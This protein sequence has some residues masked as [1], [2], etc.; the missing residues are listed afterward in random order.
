MKPIA[1]LL[2]GLPGT[3]K[4][5][6]AK[7]LEERGITRLTLDEE[8]FKR[9]GR[10]FSPKELI[11]NQDAVKT[12]FKRMTAGEIAAGHSVVVDSGF[13]K[14]TD[15]D[16]YKQLITNAGGIWKLVYFDAG[17]ETLQTRLAERNLTDAETEHVITADM[18]DSFI[19]QFEPPQGEGEQSPNE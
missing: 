4:T 17:T 18:L 8:V 6:Y 5:T 10:N 1:Y 14:K 13:W 19:A 15:R 7:K 3:G 11:P 2:C 16:E 12:D 9:Y